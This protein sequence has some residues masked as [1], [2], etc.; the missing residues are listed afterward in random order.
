MAAAKAKGSKKDDGQKAPE[1]LRRTSSASSVARSFLS[2]AIRKKGFAQ[3]EVITRWPH[4]VGP[5]LADSTV[6]IDLRFPRGERMGATLVVRCEGA[7]APLLTH[8]A[9]RVIEMVNS[10]FGYAAVAKLEVRQGPLPRKRDRRPIA[11]APLTPEAKR[12]LTT[13]VGDGELSPLREAVKSLGE[14]VLSGAKKDK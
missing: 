12:N 13:L 9:T 4:I 5:D 2:G 1:R 14:Y 8:K 3:V 7:F 6:P 10:F 11:K